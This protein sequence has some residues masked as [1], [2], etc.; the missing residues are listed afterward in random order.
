MSGAGAQIVGL[1]CHGTGPNTRAE[2]S[3]MVASLHRE[4][5]GGSSDRARDGAAPVTGHGTARAPLKGNGTARAWIDARLHRGDTGRRDSTESAQDG[6]GSRRVHRT[7]AHWTARL[8]RGN[9]AQFHATGR[10]GQDI[11][12]RYGHSMG[13]NCNRTDAQDSTIVVR[14]SSLVTRRERFHDFQYD[15]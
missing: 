10:H 7:T 5:T 2:E 15:K 4:D 6:A 13:E 8:T 1:L 9:T 12:S 11:R 14:L 3:D